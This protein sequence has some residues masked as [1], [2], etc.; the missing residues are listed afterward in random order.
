MLAAK[1]W[2]LWLVLGVAVW[3]RYRVLAPS[4][5]RPEGAQCATSLFNLSVVPQRMACSSCTPCS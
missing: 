4:C 1:N 2:W 5:R 3:I